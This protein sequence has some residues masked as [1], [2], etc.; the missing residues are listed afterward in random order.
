MGGV[1]KICQK[2]DIFAGVW[3]KKRDKKGTPKITLPAA[4]DTVDAPEEVGSTE[5]R[6]KGGEEGIIGLPGP[7]RESVGRF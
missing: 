1:K 7:S 2:L 5:R 3:Y 6:K 4:A